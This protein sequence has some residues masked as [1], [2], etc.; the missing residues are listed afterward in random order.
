MRAGGGGA[1]KGTASFFLDSDVLW[2]TGAEVISCD[3]DCDWT[4]LAS[5]TFTSPPPLVPV[6]RVHG[7]DNTKRVWQHATTIPPDTHTH[8]QTRGHMTLKVTQDD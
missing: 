6:R 5:I 3:C 4:H 2:W 8:T 1:I 7:P